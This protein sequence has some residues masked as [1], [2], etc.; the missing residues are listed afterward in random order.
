MRPSS[1]CPLLRPQR[2]ARP[3]P[4]AAH[5]LLSRYLRRNCSSCADRAPSAST[6][7]STSTPPPTDT[8]PDHRTIATTQQLLITSQYSPGSPLFLPHGARIYNKLVEFLRAQYAVHGFQEVLSPNIYKRA[9]W[10]TSGHWENFKADM[11]EVTGRGAAPVQDQEGDL[12]DDR[13]QEYGLKP[14]NCPGHCLMF[15]AT[16][17]GRSLR[18]LPVRYADFSP[19]HRYVVGACVWLALPTQLPT[20]SWWLRQW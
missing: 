7:T 17:G 8:A 13:A 12:T 9:L 5:G 2:P 1:I 19:L 3:S 16:S 11:F 15:K 4:A 10:E 14:M 6:S 18:D 20:T